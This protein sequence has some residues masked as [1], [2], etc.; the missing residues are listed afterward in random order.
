MAI[1]DYASQTNDEWWAETFQRQHPDE[2]DPILVIESE[3]HRNNQL[4][5]IRR[6][7]GSVDLCRFDGGGDD[8]RRVAGATGYVFNLAGYDDEP[9]LPILEDGDAES[10]AL[11]AVTM[12]TVYDDDLLD[13]IDAHDKAIYLDS[14]WVEEGAEGR[15]WERLAVAAV[16]ELFVSEPVFA[17]LAICPDGK[18][19]KD[20]R[21]LLSGFGFEP[22]AKTGIW[23]ASSL[24]VGIKERV[25]DLLGDEGVLFR[26]GA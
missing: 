12:A 4:E 26:W 19:G 18:A 17:C 23:F 14:A 20:W 16:L 15:G 24:S 7:H 1:F 9:Y 21:A 25:E 3:R 6:W 11:H 10:G 2:V 13:F 8:R 5:H 22:V